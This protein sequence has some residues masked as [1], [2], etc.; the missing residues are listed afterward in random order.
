VLLVTVRQHTAASTK[1]HQPCAVTYCT[2]ALSCIN[3]VKSALC[4]QLLYF[5]TKLHQPSYISP[6]QSVTLHQHTAASTRLNQP[7]AVSCCI[8][9]HSC[10]NQVTSALCSQLPCTSAH[11]CTN[12]VNQPCA[13]SCCTSP[14]SCINQVISAL[15]SQLLDITT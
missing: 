9:A 12:Q 2:S 1:L 3:Q 15:C 6:G 7:C 5:S 8:S 10:I 4:S 11:S 13:V 14:H